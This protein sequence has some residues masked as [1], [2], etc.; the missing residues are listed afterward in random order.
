MK[1]V[2]V[3]FISIFANAIKDFIKI[4]IKSNHALEASPHVIVESNGSRAVQVLPHKD[5][6]HGAIQIRNLNAVGSCVCP[7]DLPANSIHR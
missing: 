7:V 3:K 6:P 5:F 2:S 4:K 1:I